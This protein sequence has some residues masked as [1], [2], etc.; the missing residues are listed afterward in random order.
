MHTT[1][2]DEGTCFLAKHGFDRNGMPLDSSPVPLRDKA[3]FIASTFIGV[4][5]AIGLITGRIPWQQWTTFACRHPLFLDLS[6]ERTSE[7]LGI[8][9]DSVNQHMHRLYKRHPE[10]RANMRHIRKMYHERFK[11]P[12]SLSDPS[13]IEDGIRQK[14]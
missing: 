9:Q 10:I 11:H 14:W 12:L 7:L 3:D 8:S 6:V 13:F 4:L 5:Q 2:E 1:L